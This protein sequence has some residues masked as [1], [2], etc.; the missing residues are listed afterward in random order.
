VEGVAELVNLLT[1]AKAK[2]FVGL[3]VWPKL[4]TMLDDK[5]GKKSTK[6]KKKL[7]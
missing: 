5:L 3:L 2:Y 6:T 4:Y 1:N 7:S